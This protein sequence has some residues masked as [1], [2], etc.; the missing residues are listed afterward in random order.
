MAPS[1]ILP[2]AIEPNTKNSNNADS[3]KK[4][5]QE[6]QEQHEQQNK[7]RFTPGYTVVEPPAAPGEYKYEH[8]KQTFPALSWPPLEE[9]PYEDKGLLGDPQYKDLLAEATDCFDYHPKIGTEIHGV[10][11][12]ALTDAQKNDLARLIAFRGVVVFRSQHDFTLDHQLA[13]GRYFGVLH[14]HATT[15][16]PRQPGLEEVHVIWTDGSSADQRALFTPAHLWHA[17]VSLADPLCISKTASKQYI[18]GPVGRGIG[19][20]GDL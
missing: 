3:T 7:A 17:D 1:V 8:L 19:F 9:V 5:Q 4:Q 14:K 10:S 12:A 18:C 13:L 15:A 6:Q 2:T 20:T 16:V 11:L